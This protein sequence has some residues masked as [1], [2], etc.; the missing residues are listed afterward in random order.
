MYSKYGW[1]LILT[2]G[3]FYAGFVAFL[4]KASASSNELLQ[5]IAGG[6]IMADIITWLGRSIVK[7]DKYLAEFAWEALIN[8]IIVVVLVYTFDI[9]FPSQGEGMA[10]G[11]MV[12]FVACGL[13]VFWYVA[14]EISEEG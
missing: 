4:L 14:Q 5:G 11:M 2:R 12:F 6:I 8:I 3:L 1:L 9:P 7:M 13:K 10:M